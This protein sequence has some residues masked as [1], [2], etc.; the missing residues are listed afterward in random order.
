[1]T[2]APAFVR[3]GDM[4]DTRSFVPCVVLDNG[5]VLA[6]GGFQ[7]SDGHY[8]SMSAAELYDPATKAW[9]TIAG[10]MWSAR[11]LHSATKLFNSKVL[12]AGG[13]SN[14]R[15]LGSA[16]LYD[17]VKATFLFTEEMLTPRFGH[18]A[19]LLADG[20]V[21]VCGGRTLK[22]E[23]LESCELYDATL[24]TWNWGPSMTRDRFRHTATTLTD[25]RILITGGYSSTLSTTL[26]SAEIYDP[27][28]CEFTAL[29]SVMSD[30]RMDHTASLLKDGRVLIVGGWNS[31]K[32]QTV[33]SADLF[34]PVTNTFTS[35]AALPVSR[36]EHTATRLADGTV[37]LTGGLR[38]E[39]SGQ[40]TLSDAYVYRP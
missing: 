10:G 5:K 32:G 30:S 40:E 25:G 11:E 34:D 3:A 1:M 29:K 28:K 17:P 16:E 39:P 2:A 36:H 35:A 12:I 33:A 15:I 24:G 38:V 31:V 20:Q 22:D 9:S 27:I 14:K 8:R 21:L 23:S 26:A 18:T 7:S 13:F 19:T 4:I 6:P 37:L